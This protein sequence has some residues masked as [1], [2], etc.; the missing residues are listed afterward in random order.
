MHAVSRQRGVSLIEVL[1]AVLIFSIGLIGLAGLMV[2]ATRSNHSA[3]QRTQ[4]TFLAGTMAD[5][6]G[7]NPVGV[8]SGFYNSTGYPVAASTASN[9]DCSSGCT[10]Q[11][12]AAA[13]QRAWSRQ[14]STFLPNVSAVI[15]CNNGPAGYT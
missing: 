12:L 8:W 13:D 1:M 3:Y 2:M 6:M 14:L 10:P 4:V 7:A 11:A 5:R 9:N 15:S